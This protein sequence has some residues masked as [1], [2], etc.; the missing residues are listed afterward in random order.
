MSRTSTPV[1]LSCIGPYR[2][3]KI[4]VMAGREEE[5]NRVE[6][7]YS[8]ARY[9]GSRTANAHSPVLPSH[10]VPT[11]LRPRPCPPH[12][13]L[14][15]QVHPSTLLD[16][17]ARNWNTQRRRTNPRRWCSP[18]NCRPNSPALPSTAAHP[19]TSHS[20]PRTTPQVC[21]SSTRPKSSRRTSSKTPN[22]PCSAC[23]CSHHPSLAEERHQAP[24]ESRRR[25]DWIGRDLQPRWWI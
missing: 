3:Y 17:F 20:H 16:P 4:M 18:C 22:S 5:V 2:A 19:R 10:L 1:Q 6:R 9:P 21:R 11:S 12:P 24:W 15:H 25:L 14:A 23:L 13:K 8:E 7:G